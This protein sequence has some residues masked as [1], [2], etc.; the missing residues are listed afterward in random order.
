MNKKWHIE[1]SFHKR[2]A[3]HMINMTMRINQLFHCKLIAFNEFGK[4]IFFFLFDTTGI[5]DHTFVRFIK[6]YVRVFLEGIKNKFFDLKHYLDL[7]SKNKLDFCYLTD[8]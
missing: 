7:E 2:V 3:Q 1:F 8:L 6:Q 4:L 5:D